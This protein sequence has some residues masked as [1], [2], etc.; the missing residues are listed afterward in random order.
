MSSSCKIDTKL[1][2]VEDAPAMKQT[3]VGWAR[4]CKLHGKDAWQKLNMRTRAKDQH[5]PLTH[6]VKLASLEL[7]MYI[8][9]ILYDPLLIQ[10]GGMYLAK[11]DPMLK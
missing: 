3:C 10:M 2:V 5:D 6:A 7:T 9:T 11:M 1:E 8:Q 4:V